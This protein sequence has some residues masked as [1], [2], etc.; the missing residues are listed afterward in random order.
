MKYAAK[1]AAPFGFLG[2]LTEDECLAGVDFL[3][4]HDQPLPPSDPFTKNVCLQIESYLSDPNFSFDLPLKLRGT[5]F[6]NTVWL[7]IAKIS[8]GKTRL[9]GEIAQDLASA[10]RAIG[11]ACGANPVPI[12]IPC[13]RVVAKT[14][15][16]GFMHH[17][18]GNPLTIKR[19]LLAHE[20][21]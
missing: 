6:Q 5:P 12:V 3:P 13:H 11:Q 19:W 18:E 20:S 16:G 4:P 1:V 14:G 17:G 10:P 9:Y 2:I 15:L 8:K 7:E 21:D